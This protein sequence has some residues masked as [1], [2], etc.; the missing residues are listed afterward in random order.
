M[1][2]YQPKIKK[3]TSKEEKEICAKI[4]SSSDPWITL[5]ISQKAILNNLN[6][7]LNETYAVFIENII[8]GTF[9]LQTKGAFTGYLKSIALKKEWR[10]K[11]LGEKMMNYIE[12]HLFS[13]SQ[14]VFLC[15]S[16]FNNKAQIFY[17]K[18]GYEKV[19]TLTDY[20]AEGYDEI[21]M[22]KTKGPIL[23]K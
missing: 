8:V 21:L 12:D 13:M 4:M 20:I 11:N 10:G 3:I 22:R 5:G 9:V 18:L 6:D 23:D 2:L 17:Q 19:G 7:T 14:N 1:S 15:V 16:S